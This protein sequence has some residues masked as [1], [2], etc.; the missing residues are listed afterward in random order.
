MRAPLEETT[1][2]HETEESE[3]KPEGPPV[4]ALDSIPN[5]LHR[6]TDQRQV[7]RHGQ[8][9]VM[10]GTD[11]GGDQHGTDDHGQ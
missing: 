11:A 1:Y 7:G 5:E 8:D 6:H 2:Q 10:T 9:D 3:A 4:R